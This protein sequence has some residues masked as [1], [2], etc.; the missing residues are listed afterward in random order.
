MQRFVVR[1]ASGWV[2]LLLCTG[3][4]CAAANSAQPKAD[5]QSVRDFLTHVQ[6][7]FNGGDFEQFMSVFTDDAIQLSAGLPDTIGK[8]AIRKVYEDAL[9]TN[10]IKVEFHTTEIRVAGDLAFERGTFT[11]HISRRADGAHVADVTSRHIHVLRRQPDGSW[12][13]WRMMT[14]SAAPPAS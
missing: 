5:V 9:A 7:S 4:F 14:N 8:A 13:T 2:L 3:G 11:I 6:R 10:D 1:F 12:K